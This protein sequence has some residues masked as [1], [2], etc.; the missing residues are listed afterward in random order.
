MR[1][2]VF[3]TVFGLAVVSVLA[4]ALTVRAQDD[5]AKPSPDAI[6]EAGVADAGSLHQPPQTFV[7]P[8][9][10]AIPVEPPESSGEPGSV[11]FR[12][13]KR[14]S[15][16][17]PVEP[18]RSPPAEA[19][20]PVPV[21]ATAESSTEPVETEPQPLPPADTTEEEPL[22][23]TVDHDIA[24]MSF[25]DVEPGNT[26]VAEVK[27]R[28]GDPASESTSNGVLL[29]SFKMEPFQKVDVTAQNDQVTSV[30]VYLDPPM[31]PGNVASELK[32]R[33]FEPVPIPEPSG[34]LL[35]QGYP[36]RGVLFAFAAGN[37]VPKVAQIV[38]EPIAAE[39]FV[40]RALYDF[41]HRYS[42]NLADL[43]YALSL[44]ENNA[45]AHAVKSRV[46]TKIGRHAEALVEAEAA[47]RL[48]PNVPEYRLHKSLALAASGR[49]DEAIE[50]AG[51]IASEAGV[52]A[53]VKAQA[54]SALGH[55]YA[56][57]PSPDFGSS[58]EHFQKAI[59][60]ASVLTQ[61]KRFEIRRSAKLV[62]VEANAGIGHNVA[63]GNFQRKAEVSTK[64]LE[65]AGAY[66]EQFVRGDNGPK[67]LMLQVMAK[68]LAAFA[69]IGGPVK[70]TDVTDAAIQEG[71]RL[72]AWSKDSL[73][74]EYVEWTLGSALMD[75]VRIE[76]GRGKNLEAL[77]YAEMAIAMLESSAKLREL[78]PQEEFALGRFCFLAGAVH[79]VKKEDH[80]AAAEWYAKAL[81]RLTNP[82]A[83]P[84]ESQDVGRL[85]EWLVSM[86][87][88]FWEVGDQE[89]AIELTQRGSDL[90]KQAV[91]DGVMK[92]AALSVPY[93]NLS[94]M[95]RERGDKEKAD[96]FSQLAKA[97][98]TAANPRKIR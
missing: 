75:A 13:P 14:P 78:L 89:K 86:G 22:T 73:F 5:S 88:T 46:L 36:E 83:T 81:P 4:T 85:G 52:S 80:N 23:P 24:T 8:A 25:N 6:D 2:L 28:W 84:T 29:L 10:A 37:D 19:A 96:G 57:L 9:A 45:Q 53:H 87:V 70:S 27:E 61:D 51:Q 38:V 74:K 17:K 55:F 79:A 7:A 33:Q 95:H 1:T 93:S 32:L 64:W 18:N 62:L 30:V 72:V 49:H 63:K 12:P 92:K 59:S 39:P 76:H 43:D 41:N 77:R 40:L 54:E 65:R 34:Q 82:V 56:H 44:D 16:L 68:R 3:R 35:G 42:N 60:L 50:V 47:S 67:D 26:T 48:E 69:E 21:V 90:I 66:A 97:L 31:L 94:A 58:N 98:E 71:R 91:D 20:Q 15:Q 11:V